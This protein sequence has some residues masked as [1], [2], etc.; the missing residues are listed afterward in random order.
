[1]PLFVVLFENT[2]GHLTHLPRAGTREFSQFAR[3]SVCE[4][5]VAELVCKGESNKEIAAHLGKSVL[6]V[7]TQLQS[8]YGKLGTG[9]G[10][11]ISLLFE[12]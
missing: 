3:L 1:M 5:E 8:I 4:R 7:K 9:R 12:R 6:T 2:H 10:R 11:L